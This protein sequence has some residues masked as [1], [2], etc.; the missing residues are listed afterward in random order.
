MFDIKREPTHPGD[1]LFHE[2]MEPLGIS[3]TQLAKDLDTT[4]RTINE[5][6]NHKRGISPEMAVRLARYFGTSEE[7]WINLQMQYELYRVKEK[8]KKALGKVRAYTELHTA[9]V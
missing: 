1:I 4:F 8:K 9:M 3:Q 7:L 5:I 6:I 2:F